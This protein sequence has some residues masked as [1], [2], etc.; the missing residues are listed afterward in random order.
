MKLD[1]NN[2]RDYDIA[3]ALRG[4]DL[5]GTGNLKYVLTCRIRRLVGCSHAPVRRGRVV[6]STAE[7]ALAEV[8]ARKGGIDRGLEHYMHHVYQAAEHLG[9]EGLATLVFGLLYGPP[10]TPER[11]IELA[12]GD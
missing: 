8:A 6:E 7:A 3:C 10:P 9:D 1:T 11:L 12:G 2:M 4:P 5:P